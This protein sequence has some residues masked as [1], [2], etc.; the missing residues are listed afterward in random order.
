[1]LYQETKKEEGRSSVSGGEM[2][3]KLE[4]A[5]SKMETILSLL[6]TNIKAPEKCAFLIDQL[7]E[8]SSDEVDFYI[9]QLV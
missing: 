8:L 9:M 1:M 6:F 3:E 7:N 2:S 4:K 5:G